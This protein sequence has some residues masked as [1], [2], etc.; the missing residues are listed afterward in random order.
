[1][2]RHNAHPSR[3]L[4]ESA[5]L[6]GD[7]GLLGEAQHGRSR[8]GELLVQVDQLLLLQ[9]D[10]GCGRGGWP[11]GGWSGGW[12][13]V[14]VHADA[15]VGGQSGQAGVVAL[16]D[17]AELPAAAAPVEL[18]EH[19]GRLG[20]GIGDVEADQLHAGRIQQPQVQ[21]GNS[22]EA[23]TVG[24]CGQH[25]PVDGRLQARR[26]HREPVHGARLAE[27]SDSA[28]RMGRLVVEHKVGVRSDLAR[29]GE[30]QCRG[31]DVGATSRGSPRQLHLY[32]GC[33]QCDIGPFG[34]RC[35]LFMVPCHTGGAQ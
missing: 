4:A 5:L 28:G 32:C 14:G 3:V 1:M 27:V 30:Q 23:A 24:G 13:R 10:R 8:G 6:Q 34:H 29:V 9:A 17:R 18:A 2:S 35:H 31:V 26:V 22:T 11:S 7:R 25:H 20:A 21:A 16:P 12:S 33:P 15:E 19:E